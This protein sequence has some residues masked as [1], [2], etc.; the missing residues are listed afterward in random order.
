MFNIFSRSIIVEYE[1]SISI[2]D[3]FE[4]VK[5]DFALLE[6]VNDNMTLKDNVKNKSV[7]LCSDGETE[8]SVTLYSVHRFDYKFLDDK[9]KS[10]Y[11]QFKESLTKSS[12]EIDSFKAFSFKKCNDY[13]EKQSNRSFYTTCLILFLAF[14]F[15]FN[16]AQENFYTSFNI[17]SLKNDDF[18]MVGYVYDKESNKYLIGLM[19]ENN[20][21]NKVFLIRC[22]KEP[23]NKYVNIFYK[24]SLKINYLS[25][26]FEYIEFEEIVNCAHITTSKPLVSTKKFNI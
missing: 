23:V 14:S 20:K 25:Q 11:Q 2:Y 10:A 17:S 24:D 8:Y 18:E 1:N 9:V 21:S 3:N 15:S 6:H 12:F 26:S 13:Q 7:I 16:Y 4:K 22:D 5:N 19:F